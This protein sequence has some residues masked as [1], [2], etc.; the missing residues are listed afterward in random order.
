MSDI[1]PPKQRRYRVIATSGF[2]RYRAQVR[3]LGMWW[4]I[5]GSDHEDLAKERCERH[6]QS[7]VWEGCLP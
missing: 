5:G 7:V 3:R 2:W 1:K 6:A 4:N